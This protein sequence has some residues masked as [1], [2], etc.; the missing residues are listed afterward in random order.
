MCGLTLAAAANSQPPC[1]TA[2]CK[3]RVLKRQ[4][5]QRQ[6]A[7]CNTWRCVHRAH[8]R[9]V[10]RLG[11]AGNRALGYQLAAR[12]GWRGQQWACLDRLWQHESGWNH[13]ARNGS[14]GAHGIPQSL[15]G[16]KMASAGADWYSSAATQIR[17][18]LGYIASAYG[19]P[20]DAW[21]KW[22]GRWP[23]WY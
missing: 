13:R 4:Q 2:V 21:G 16:S 15:P 9:Q 5:V 23:H 14:S 20:C 22:L 1:K 12:R 17:W 10:R 7:F 19:T 8:R 18:G 3:E 6:V 11:L